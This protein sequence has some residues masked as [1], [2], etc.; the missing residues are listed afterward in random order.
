[1]TSPKF[2]HPDSSNLKKDEA[3][4]STENTGRTTTTQPTWESLKQIQKE[5]PAP[6]Q[7]KSKVHSSKVDF[8]CDLSSVPMFSTN[9]SAAAPISVIAAYGSEHVHR[10]VIRSKNWDF[11]RIFDDNKKYICRSDSSA[12]TVHDLILAKENNVFLHIEGLDLSVYAP[13]MALAKDVAIH[14]CLKYA[15]PEKE[16]TGC[17]HLL[18]F[19]SDGIDTESVPLEKRNQLDDDHLDLF[20]G[21]GFSK[22][23][24]SFIHFMQNERSGLSIFEGTPGTGKTSYIRYLIGKLKSTHRFYF[25]PPA[26][27]GVLTN[28]EFIRF[29]A[30]QNATYS[31]HRF[32]CVLEDAD[33]ALMMRDLDNRREV[34]A[35]LNITDGLLADFLRLQVVCSINCSST[36]IDPAL[37]RPGR[38]HTHLLFD[39]IPPCR[40]QRISKSVGR[41]ISEQEDYSLAEI[42]NASAS[43]P[44]SKQAIGFAA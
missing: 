44:F 16:D 28:P 23:N 17:Y 34:G 21:D 25:I 38:L 7:K 22:K 33:S 40:A 27:T 19:G 26:S 32:V 4:T 18:T 12:A 43:T 2:N 8:T 6:S 24:E 31:K 20:Y 35:I 13:E 15:M 41:E 14:F 30:R 1:M 29:W 3:N 9:Y 11:Q 5:I 36:E 37:I 39:R 42:F 10:Y